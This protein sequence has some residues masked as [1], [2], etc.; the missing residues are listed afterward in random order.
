MAFAVVAIHTV[1]F[2]GCEN[3]KFLCVYDNLV[4]LAVPFFFLASGYL[5]AIKMDYPYGSAKDLSR[6]KG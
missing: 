5:L 6:I 1:L 3:D 4:S 2:E